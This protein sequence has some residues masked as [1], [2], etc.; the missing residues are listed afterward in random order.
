MA[1]IVID[2]QNEFCAAGG[3]MDREGN[4]LA[5]VQ[6]MAVV[7]VV[8]PLVES[9]LRAGVFVVFLTNVYSTAGSHCLSDVWL[10]QVARR[11]VGSHT[12]HPVCGAD[13]W[14]GDF[15]PTTSALSSSR[16]S[17]ERLRRDDPPQGVRPRLL[18]CRH[19][20]QSG[21]LQ[22]RRTH[23]VARRQR[24]VFGENCPHR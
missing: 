16:A 15:Y 13:S 5:A 17:H 7:V 4:D 18:C 12:I 20:R 2:V 1:P 8:S 22:R 14:E 19:R 10:E 21:D 11:R 3:M 6:Q 23:R 9:V 24:P